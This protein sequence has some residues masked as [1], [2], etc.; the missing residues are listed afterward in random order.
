MVVITTEMVVALSLGTQGTQPQSPDEYAQWVGKSDQ[1][2]FDDMITHYSQKGEAY[3]ALL[4]SQAS[5]EFVPYSG[6]PLFNK[7]D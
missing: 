5:G 4:K 2:S 3:Q 7:K 6:P 1:Q